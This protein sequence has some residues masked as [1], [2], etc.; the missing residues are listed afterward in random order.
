MNPGWSP[1]QREILETMGLPV[2]RAVGV[3]LPGELP[4]DPLVHALL[5]AAG[6]TRDAE[7]AV[8][9]AKAWPSPRTLCTDPR[10]KRAL[11]PQLRA[12]RRSPAS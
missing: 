2:Y 5:R 12:L 7:D 9:L 4:D 8:R 10:A 6:R 3:A 1:L 11:W